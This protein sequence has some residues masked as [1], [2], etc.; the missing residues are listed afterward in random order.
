M[1]RICLPD[2]R[3]V[4]LKIS[5]VGG[6]ELNGAMLDKYLFKSNCIILVYDITNPGTF[7]YMNVWIQTINGLIDSPPITA[8][9]GNKC[10]LEHQRAVRLDKTQQFV[11]DFELS[12]FLVSA[13][14]GECVS[15]LRYSFPL[16]YIFRLF[17]SFF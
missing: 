12:N 2:K 5:D 13:K 15:F 8:I 17:D 6:L 4:T 16:Y 1:K 9:V 7:D 14:T 11:H 10:D 3:E